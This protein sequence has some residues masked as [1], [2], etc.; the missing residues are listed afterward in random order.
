ALVSQLEGV[1][2]DLLQQSLAVKVVLTFFILAGGTALARLSSR[3]TRYLWER[4]LPKGEVAERIRKRKRS[5]DQIVEYAV[6][7]LTLAVATLYI[8]SSAVSNI[9]SQIALYTPRVI[10]AILVFLLGLVL[11]KGVLSGIRAFIENLDVKKQAETVGVSPKVLDGFLVGI[12]FF[13]YLV[14]VELS[15]IQLGVSSAII[16]NTITAASYGIVLLL[17]LLGF[18]GFKDLL[19]NYAAGIY[20]RSSDVLKPGK[21]VKMDDETGEIR[22]ISAFGTT[23]TTDSGYFMLSPNQKLMDREILFKRV[24]ADVE[25]LEDITDYFVAQDPS[26]CGP[27]SAEMALAMFGFDMSQGDLAEKSGTEVGEGVE[28]EPLM[29]AVEEMTGEEVRTAYIE[30]DRITDLSDEFKAWF[31]DGALIIP[32]FAKP[33]LFPESHR[34][35]HYALSVGAEGREL[36]IVDPSAHTVSGGVYYV[37]GSEMREAM[38][39]WEGKKRGYIVLAP[40]GTTAYWRLKEDLIYSDTGLYDQLSKSLELQLG[41]ILRQG[42]ILKQVTPDAVE[43]FLEQW[44]REEKVKRVW[45]PEREQGGEKKLDEFTHSDE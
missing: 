24:K 15:I 41:R 33:V 39:E 17:A 9:A 8:N 26:Y 4:T 10:T 5:P 34:G 6:V 16:N 11:V 2:L 30:H 44:R 32:N 36:L 40:K 35:G 21:R 18:F 13:L 1:A 20:L 38:D 19:Q 31:N 22:E 43:D 25:T 29:D 7:V 37:E 42:R 12:K 45:T 27:A 23:V 28:P 14:V 3:L